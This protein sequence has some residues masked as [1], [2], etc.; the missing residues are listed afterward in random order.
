MTNTQNAR[1]SR[2]NDTNIR[3]YTVPRSA[4]AALRPLRLRLRLRLEVKSQ[5]IFKNPSKCR[6]FK[7]LYI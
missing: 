7:Q 4:A 3:V 5:V 2:F 1:T 6:K